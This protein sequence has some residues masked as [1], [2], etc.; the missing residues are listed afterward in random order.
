MSAAVLVVYDGRPEDPER[1]LRYYVEHHVPIVWTFPG[2]RAVQVERTVVGDVFMIARFLF[3][4]P[5]DARAALASPERARARADRDNFP[6]FDGTVRHQIVEVL[7]I[8]RTDGL[9]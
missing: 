7:D 4:S 6:R 1:F 8:P 9:L 3:D 5:E 2:I